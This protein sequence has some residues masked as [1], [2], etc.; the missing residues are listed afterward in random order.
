VLRFDARCP[1]GVRGTPPHL[2]LLALRDDR[3]VAV[4]AQCTGYLGRKRSRV[5]EA[6]RGLAVGADLL[7]WQEEM[8]RLRD[9]PHRYR[10]L[11][12][13]ALVKFAFGLGRTFPDRPVTLLY[14]YWEPLDAAR[15][16]AFLR[17]RAELAL[18]AERA[19]G[20]GVALVAQTFEALWDDW[21][22]SGR[23]GIETQ[24][25]HLLARYAV[26]LDGAPR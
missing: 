20:T 13:A 18:L 10:H 5:A 9:D 22:G 3:V 21:R 6:Y 24:I 1:T 26:T 23:P 7:P 15:H 16:P 17:H 19:A 2:D 12:A 8:L 4:T 25:R 14:L 11:D